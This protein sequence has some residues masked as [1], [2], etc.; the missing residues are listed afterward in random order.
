MTYGGEYETH[1]EKA[2][3]GVS[4][5]GEEY[6]F[7]SAAEAERVLS[8]IYN[9]SFSHSHISHVCNGKRKS[10][11]GWTF[12]FSDEEGKK[13]IPQYEGNRGK[14]N[15]PVIAIKMDTLEK[16]VYPSAAQASRE[17]G[18]DKTSISKCL[19]KLKP[20]AGGYEFIYYEREEE[21]G[22]KNC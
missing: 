15:R 5:Y 11:K 8:S 22:I 14:M 4:P 21:N 16:T 9:D 3:I 2:V 20:Q 17:L 18:I 10:H 7:K 13:N 1:R 19:R 12:Y 6:N